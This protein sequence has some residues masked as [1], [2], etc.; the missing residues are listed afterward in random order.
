MTTSKDRHI[1]VLGQERRRRWSVEE[2]LAMVRE[3]LASGQS[4]S[5]VARRNGHQSQPVVPLAQALLV[6]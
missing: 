3:S 1:E 5:V 2:K 6:L 4:V